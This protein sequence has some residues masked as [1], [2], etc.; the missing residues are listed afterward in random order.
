MSIHFTLTAFRMSREGYS[1]GKP[2]PALVIVRGARV[3]QIGLFY[4]FAYTIN[5]GFEG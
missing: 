5:V 1:I 2:G 3:T 4:V